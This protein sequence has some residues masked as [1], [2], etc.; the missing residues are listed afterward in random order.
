MKKI[1]LLPFCLL[2]FVTCIKVSAQVG[3]NTTDP[4]TTLDVNGA[5]TQREVSFTVASNAANINIETSLANIT[6]TATATV[7]VTAY[8]PTING[9]MLIISNNTTGGFGATFAGTTIPNAQAIGYVYTNGAWKTTMG[10]STTNM[11]NSDGT[12]TSN[13][14]VALG[15]NNLTF[16]G[17]GRAEFQNSIGFAKDTRMGISTIYNLGTGDAYGLEQV[18]N[19][20]S[21]TTP[22]LRFFTA[23]AASAHLAFGK[24]TSATAFTEYARFITNGY[25]GI[26]ISSPTANLEVAASTTTNNTVVNATGSINDF[27]QINIKNTNTS[28]RAQSGYSATADNGSD[29]SG[30][31]WIGIN[32]STFN[33]PTAYNIGVGNDV[34]YI[35]SGQDMYIANANNT[36]SIIFSTG[37]ATTPF[38]NERMR[39]TNAGKLG[40]GTTSPNSTLNVNGSF[41]VKLASIN[42]TSTLPDDVCK[43]M[44]SN[45]GTNITITLPDPTTCTGRMLSF[46]RFSSSTGTITL[47]PS[48]G[49][50]QNLDGTLSAS[51][52]IAAHSATGGGVNIQFWSNGTNWYR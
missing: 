51:T 38:F 50:I 10:S 34:S 24:Y 13:R 28:S 46:S 8:T 5:V 1:T 22:A 12:L 33:Y 25:F 44:L 6:G 30:F 43:V 31:A 37:K 40:I 29:S 14:T 36:K 26:G 3:I 16:T 2:M 21:G 19:T 32:N 42:S 47:S 45:G 7:V 52:T 23:N 4:R 11:Y 27:L 20:Q 41:A 49:S 48:A 39:L 17:T 35:G 18:S 9:H 15:A